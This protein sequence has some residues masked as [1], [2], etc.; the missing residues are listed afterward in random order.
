M[1]VDPGGLLGSTCGEWDINNR[2]FAF[3][4]YFKSIRVSRNTARGTCRNASRNGRRVG[5][6]SDT[7]SLENLFQRT[8]SQSGDPR[9]EISRDFDRRIRELAAK[10]TQTISHAG[11]RAV[12]VGVLKRSRI[13]AFFTR[14]SCARLLV[15]EKSYRCT[16][17]RARLISDKNEKQSSPAY[18]ISIAVSIYYFLVPA[19]ARIMYL[20]RKKENVPRLCPFTYFE[21]VKT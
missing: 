16:Y 20:G 6:A 9:L 8:A 21:R 12:R 1:P 15:S 4:I 7:Q 17:M 10:A 19:Y 13:A 2:G 3:L 18:S 5:I 11:T 14:R